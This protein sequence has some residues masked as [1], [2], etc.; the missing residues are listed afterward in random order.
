MRFYLLLGAHVQG[1]QEEK[2]EKETLIYGNKPLNK[3]WPI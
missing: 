3:H 1:N 2:L